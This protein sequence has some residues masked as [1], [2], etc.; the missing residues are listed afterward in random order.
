MRTLKCVALVTWWT[1]HLL[2]WPFAE[3]TS[4]VDFYGYLLFYLSTNHL[5]INN[6][7]V[8]HGCLPHS[9]A[10]IYFHPLYISSSTLFS[11]L[12]SVAWILNFCLLQQIATV[13]FIFWWQLGYLS[14]SNVYEFNG[15]LMRNVCLSSKDVHISFWAGNNTI[16]IIW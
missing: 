5:L 15:V 9:W 7:M 6:S 14:P 2:T 13:C 10:K 1:E 11:C 16:E 8:L 4:G 12:C 3:E